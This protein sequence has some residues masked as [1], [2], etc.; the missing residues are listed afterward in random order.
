METPTLME[1][2]MLMPP[3]IIA[4]HQCF[5]FSPFD[6]NG[7]GNIPLGKLPLSSCLY[8]FFDQ[9]LTTLIDMPPS[10]T[11][12]SLTNCGKKQ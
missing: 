1:T 8:S 3:V 5:H 4:P 11:I 7:K 2:L 9:R 10:D 6:I 12:P